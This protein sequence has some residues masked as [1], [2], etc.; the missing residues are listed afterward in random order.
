MAKGLCNDNPCNSR[1][2]PLG[3][4][5]HAIFCLMPLVV[6]LISCGSTVVADVP[7]QPANSPLSLGLPEGLVGGPKAWT[8][9][10]GLGSSLQVMLLLAVLSLRPPCC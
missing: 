5:R 8:S 6:C 7:K 1:T 10:E 3:R 9:P 2:N 4:F